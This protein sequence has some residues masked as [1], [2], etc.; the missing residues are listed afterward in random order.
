MKNAVAILAALALSSAVVFADDR[1]HADHSKNDQR[2]QQAFEQHDENKDGKISKEEASTN[3]VLTED[4]YEVDANE[5]GSVDITE[6]S[7]FEPSEKHSSGDSH[8]Q[9]SHKHK[10]AG[11]DA[12]D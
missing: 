6:F 12:D 11:S 4:W 5:D 2:K 7:R 9:K 10:D 3:M 8:M 1:Q